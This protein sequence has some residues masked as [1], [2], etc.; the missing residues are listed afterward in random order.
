LGAIV[1]SSTTRGREMNTYKTTADFGPFGEKHVEIDYIYVPADEDE[2]AGTVVI[3]EGTFYDI[4]TK[5][6]NLGRETCCNIIDEDEL[7][8][9][10]ESQLDAPEGDI[11]AMKRKEGF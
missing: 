3:Y 9:W 2:D 7:R 11:E 6:H 4:D 5:T 8:E 1:D 10:H